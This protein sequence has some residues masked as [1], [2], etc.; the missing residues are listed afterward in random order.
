[1]ST[2]L[3]VRDTTVRELQEKRFKEFLDGLEKDVENTEVSFDEI[4]QLIED[5][6]LLPVMLAADIHPVYN[7]YTAEYPNVLV[8]ARDV[9][10]ALLRYL[11]EPNPP[12]AWKALD[13]V[14]ELLQDIT[15]RYV[16]V[17]TEQVY[18]L[19]GYMRLCQL[20]AEALGRDP[21]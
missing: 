9:Q 6:Q 13:K 8:R 2:R 4:V 11:T 14:K 10:Y 5:F 17:E 15:K 21:S 3:F 20:A 1:M 19:P 16:R 18:I 12:V 7:E